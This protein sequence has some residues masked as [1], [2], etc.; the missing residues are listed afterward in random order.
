MRQ[1]KAN[2]RHKR[3][4]TVTHGQTTQ[5]TAILG[6]QSTHERWTPQRLKV[7]SL[8]EG[9]QTAEHRLDEYD[10]AISIDRH[11]MHVRRGTHSHAAVVSPLKDRQRLVCFADGSRFFAGELTA[12]EKQLTGLIGRK[13]KT[14]VLLLQVQETT[15]VNCI[16]P[17]LC[18]RRVSRRR[19]ERWFQQ[20]RFP[21]GM[22]SSNRLRDQKNRMVGCI[23]QL[24]QAIQKLFMKSAICNHLAG[25]LEI[26]PVGPAS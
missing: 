24:L 19:D 11:V 17:R 1:I 16:E 20:K 25:V 26:Q 7:R 21:D 3:W 15:R 9:C 2:D 13:R 10:A 23:P 5:V 14:A 6:N 8:T 12:G 18:C 22:T 4:L